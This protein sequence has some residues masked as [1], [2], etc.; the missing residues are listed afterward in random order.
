MKE[1]LAV[2]ATVSI[3]FII[4]MLDSDPV[5]SLLLIIHFYAFL[6]LLKGGEKKG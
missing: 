5:L 3:L 6:G 2:L 4:R 1:F